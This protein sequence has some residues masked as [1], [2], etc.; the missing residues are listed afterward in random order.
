MLY[1]MKIS[2][3]WCGRRV[4]SRAMGSSCV[5]IYIFFYC[6]SSMSIYR[7]F[8]ILNC[9]QLFRTCSPHQYSALNKKFFEK[10]TNGRC[11]WNKLSSF[12]VA[13]NVWEKPCTVDE[14]TFVLQK[15]HFGTWEVFTF[16]FF[17]WLEHMTCQT[18]EV[19]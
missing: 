13:F 17:Q 8:H 15:S 18:W 11:L 19:V 1:L 10:L 3:N 12:Y 7:C 4:S 14:A 16:E 5:S 6:K 9:R 2:G